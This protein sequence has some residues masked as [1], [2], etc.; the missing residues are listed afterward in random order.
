MERVAPIHDPRIMDYARARAHSAALTQSGPTE[1]SPVPLTWDTKDVLDNENVCFLIAEEDHWTTGVKKGD[2]ILNPVT[3]A[4]IWH[5]MNTGIGRITDENVG[6][7][8]ARIKLVETVYGPS[9]LTS[10]GPKA[11]TMED[12]IAHIGLTTNASYKEESRASF[13]KRHVTYF[14]DT[15]KRSLERFREKAATPA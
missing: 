11:I 10:E 1:R 8:Y 12:V 5:S 3:N 4:L 6:E 7:V 2:R 14:L 9:L 15:S 13:Y